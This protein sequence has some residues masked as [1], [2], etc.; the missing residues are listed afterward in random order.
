MILNRKVIHSL[1]VYVAQCHTEQGVLHGQRGLMYT[2]YGKEALLCR[3]IRDVGGI[4][5]CR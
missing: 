2:L 5:V 4:D 1:C 3:V